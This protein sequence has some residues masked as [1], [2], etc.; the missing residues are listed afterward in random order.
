MAFR[1]TEV[2]QVSAVRSGRD[3]ESDLS[4]ALIAAGRPSDAEYH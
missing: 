1:V 4:P 2:Q 3:C